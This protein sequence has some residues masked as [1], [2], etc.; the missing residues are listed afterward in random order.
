MNAARPS[1]GPP[2]PAHQPKYGASERRTFVSLVPGFFCGSCAHGMRACFNV[3]RILVGRRSLDVA[4][5][6]HLGDAVIQITTPL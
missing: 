4:Q 1:A 6:T 5:S 3:T 2:E